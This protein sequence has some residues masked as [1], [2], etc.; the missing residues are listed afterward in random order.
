LAD[1]L[2][3]EIRVESEDEGYV[4]LVAEP[5]ERGY[6][7]TLGNA[8]RRVLLSSLSG[9]AITSVRIE[10]VEHEFSTVPGMKE[11]VTEFLLNLKEVRLRAFADRPA[12]LFLEVSGAGDVTTGQIQATA[13]YE[14]VNPD[15][16]LATLDTKD[17]TL[18]VDLHVETGRGYLPASVSEGVPIGVIPVDAL[19]S[20]VRRVNYQVSNTRVGQETNCDRLDL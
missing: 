2:H 11:D 7:T 8:L 20:P 19:F 3:P 16:V 14:I 18:V 10:G 13:D 15:Q 17:A 1:L 6:G 4:H 5:L 12:R 9:A